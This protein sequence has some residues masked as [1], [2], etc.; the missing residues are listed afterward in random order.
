[1]TKYYSIGCLETLTLYQHLYLLQINGPRYHLKLTHLV[2]FWW[3][4]LIVELER[5]DSLTLIT[6]QYRET[7]DHTHTH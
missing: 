5:Q 4:L 6:F 7:R 3:W 1:M 2:L